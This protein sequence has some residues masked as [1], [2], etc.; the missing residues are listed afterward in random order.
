MI[1]SGG[2]MKLSLK[3]LS[4]V[5]AAGLWGALLN[6]LAVWLFGRLGIAPALGVHI[7]PPLTPAF[8]YP[9]LVWG[10]LWGLLFLV[11]MGRLSLPVRGLIFSLGPSLAQ[12]FWVFPLKAHQGVLGLH[13]GLLTPVFVLFYNAVWGVAAGLWL[14][15]VHS[16]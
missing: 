16:R 4:L 12:L 1:T 9:R 11:P 3:N 13:L 7:A 2:T 15:G 14:K 8:L 6:S 5:F 10:G